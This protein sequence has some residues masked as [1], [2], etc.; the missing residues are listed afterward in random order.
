[1]IRKFGWVK[2]NFRGDRIPAAAGL[3]IV[4]YGS[5]GAV[6]ARYLAI[7]SDPSARLYLIALLGFG[8]L[9]LADDIFGSREVGGF[10]GH[11]IVLYLNKKFTTGAAKAIGGGLISIYLGYEAS[12]G[13]VWIW[14]IDSMIIALAA[15]TLNLFDLRP[16]R[17]LSIFFLGLAAVVLAAWTRLSAPIPLGSVAVA[18]A[19]VA[20]YDARGKAM[21][22]D[23]GS[24]AL[25][26]ALGLTF[27][28]D[29]G[30]VGKIIAI[31]VFLMINIYSERCS[32]SEL[33]E[34]HPILAKID[35]KLGIR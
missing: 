10:R 16:G 25:G 23:V 31:A 6:L 20:Y 35:S 14:A 26:A 11:F 24:N 33:I 12:G 28:L 8:L 2:E 7:G 4:I 30:S 27:A 29:A 15:N 17:A 22:G 9:G 19:V 32:I 13:T 21:L 5:A 34:R 18:A 1:M 3:Y